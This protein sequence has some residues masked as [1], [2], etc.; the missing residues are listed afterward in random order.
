MTHEEKGEWGAEFSLKA[1]DYCDRL[2]ST[3]SGGAK[4]DEGK[5]EHREKT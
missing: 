3:L 2:E 1:E 5:D 4:T